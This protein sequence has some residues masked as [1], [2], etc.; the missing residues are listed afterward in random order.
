VTP[1]VG[2]QLPAEQLP[3]GHSEALV[4]QAGP[5]ILTLRQ[6][7]TGSQVSVVHGLPSSQLFTAPLRQAPA[8]Q[9]SFTVQAL[10]S[11]QLTGV[12]GY[13]QFPPLQDPA[14]S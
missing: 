7:E 9:K 5:L 4:V 11:S 6:P 3:V 10:L 2:R 1:A 12:V 8:S 14:E 13:S